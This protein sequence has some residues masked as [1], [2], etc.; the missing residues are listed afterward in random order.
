MSQF[1]K[2]FSVLVIILILS[3]CEAENEN[4]KSAI[5]P[6]KKEIYEKIINQK[7]SHPFIIQGFQDAAEFRRAQKSDLINL[8]QEIIKAKLKNRVVFD[9]KFAKKIKQNLAQELV[10]VEN[11]NAAAKPLRFYGFDESMQNPTVNPAYILP[12]VKANKLNIFIKNGL[13]FSNQKILQILN[14]KIIGHIYQ[15]NYL[16]PAPDLMS[17]NE[18]NIKSDATIPS[19]I[20]IMLTTLKT[21]D[22]KAY[23]QYV[24]KNLEKS[25]LFYWYKTPR[26]ADFDL[27][28]IFNSARNNQEGMILV[29]NGYS[30]GGSLGTANFRKNKSDLFTMP[31]DCSSYISHVAGL[32]ADPFIDKNYIMW[33]ADLHN[34]NNLMLDKNYISPKEIKQN[35]PAYGA[36]SQKLEAIEFDDI[37][38]V[39]EGDLLAFRTFAGE[40]QKLNSLG[41]GGHIGIVL[42]SDGVDEIYLLSYVRH[43]EEFNTGGFL[44]S[45]VSFKN[46]QNQFR[47]ASLFRYKGYKNFKEEKENIIKVHIK[48]LDCELSYGIKKY[49]CA[50]GRSGASAGKIEGDGK[51]PTGIFDLKEVFIRA[52]K[53]VIANVK[54]KLPLIKIQENYGWCDN[55]KSL[56]YNKFIY[57]PSKSCPNST[58]N[59]YRQDHV[60]DLILPIGFNDKNIIPGKGSAIFLH[61]AK[62]NYKLTAGCVA[63]KKEDLLELLAQIDAKTKIKITKK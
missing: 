55:Q 43:Y 22:L 16:L 46:I 20:N 32:K 37:E 11:F 2:N 61:V 25:S 44:I 10:Y 51:T 39:R 17:E 23:Q 19:V 34:L 54:T 27:D 31:H 38:K 50:A 13:S 14:G 4:P 7:F 29:H 53:I 60:Y 12:Q 56:K 30:F 33:T 58:E 26:G 40:K 8:Y 6:L 42:G 52:D 9:A 63:L 24:Q 36:F 21:I 35:L 41:K 5:V 49:Q 15:Q 28:S 59:L 45:A 57:L 18:Q 47:A 62:E 3:S 48:G 1:F